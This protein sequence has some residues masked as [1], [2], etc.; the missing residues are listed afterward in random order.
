[1]LIRGV[2][3]RVA[4]CRIHHGPHNG[5]LLNGNEHLIEFN[6]LYELCRE[7]G[8]VGAFYLGRD[9]TERGNVVRYNFF[10]HLGGLGLGSM[11]VYLD[12]CASGVTVFGN[13]FYRVQRAAFIG[14]GRDNRVENNIFVDC[15]PAVQI[16]GRGLDKSPVWHG[17]VYDTMKK[18]LE[19]MNW[20]QPPYSERYPQL[21]DLEKYYAQDEG[22]P[23]EG[24]V[25]ARNICVGEWLSIGWHA[26]PEMVEVRDNLVN[27]DPRF[28]D[29]EKMNFQLRP[30]SPAWDLGFERIPF[31]EI[32]PR[33]K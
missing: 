20:R 14:G 2:G 10:H 12:D 26:Q 30:D 15:K 32:G 27:Q 1:V 21:A 31:E 4:H 23:P 9:W 28:V 19:E 17:M 29:A 16:D 11:A 8:D 25:V 3:N 22:V 24:N 7:T 18:R 13:V 6:E 5:I 33:E